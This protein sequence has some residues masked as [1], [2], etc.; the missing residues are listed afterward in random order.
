MKFAM[1]L[2][3]AVIE[4]VESGKMTK[5]LAILVQH[6][7]KPPRETWRSTKEFLGDVDATFRKKMRLC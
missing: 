3:S 7:R 1:D 6:T 5:D 4:T 2:E